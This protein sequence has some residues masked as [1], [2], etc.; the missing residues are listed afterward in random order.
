MSE[1]GTLKLNEIFEEISK[2]MRSDFGRSRFAIQLHPGLKGEAAEN[3]VKQF[4]ENYIP[5]SWCNR[6]YSC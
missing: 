5:N 1:E 2:T 3:I 6:R 4:L